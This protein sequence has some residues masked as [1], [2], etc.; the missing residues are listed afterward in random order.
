MHICMSHVCIICT[1]P[2]NTL[3]CV[4]IMYHFS[5]LVISDDGL[6]LILDLVVMKELPGSH[7][8]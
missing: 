6:Y 7:T 8:E 5:I 1:W 3:S 2:H 4:L